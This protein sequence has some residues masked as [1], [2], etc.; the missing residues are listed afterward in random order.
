MAKNEDKEGA[1]SHDLY[2]G[3]CGGRT[4]KTRLWL[5]LLILLLTAVGWA[6]DAPDKPEPEKQMTVGEY[7]S[8]EFGAKEEFVGPMY[9]QPEGEVWSPD[10]VAAW[11]PDE[12]FLNKLQQ[13]TVV[14]VFICLLA[15]AVLWMVGK[16]SPSLIGKGRS[17]KKF[18]TVLERQSIGP[19]RAVHTLKV[20]NKILVVG[21]T[22]HN[23]QTLCEM[24]P[25]EYQAAVA[26]EQ[27]EPEMEMAPA[28][29][30]KE[31]YGKILQHYLSILPKVG[32]KNES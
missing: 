5:A 27:E 30:A 24:T 3:R 15:S 9:P 21:M 19:N 13:V 1:S 11:A 2:A 22:D 25:E 7:I 28:E 6:Q 31:G 23:M 16:F 14:C 32:V 20:G 29:A 17:R 12:L 18:V 4:L 10:P 8:S 26:P